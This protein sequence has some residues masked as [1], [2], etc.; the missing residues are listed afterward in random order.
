M[1]ALKEISIQGMRDRLVSRVR[2]PSN[3]KESLVP[4]DQA[5]EREM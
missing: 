2:Q 3:R 1:L 5:A 4:T